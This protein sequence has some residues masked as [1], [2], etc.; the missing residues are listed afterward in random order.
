MGESHNPLAL[1]EDHTKRL[2]FQHRKEL[3]RDE[4]KQQQ[5]YTGL[6]GAR[7][8]NGV[9]RIAMGLHLSTLQDTG[10]WMGRSGAK[11]FRRFLL[12]EGIQPSAAYQYMTVAKTFLLEH[13]VV[14]ER[15][16]MVSMRLLVAASRYLRLEDPEAGTEANTD[17]IVSIVTSMPVAEALQLLR[18]WYEPLAVEA[19]MPAPG[20]VSRPVAGILNTVETLTHE[21]RAEL[22]RALRFKPEAVPTPRTEKPSIQVVPKGSVTPA[23]NPVPSL[24]SGIHESGTNELKSPFANTKSSSARQF[25][26]PAFIAVT[27]IK[28]LKT[29]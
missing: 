10:G 18:E 15:I 14:P 16:A 27:A 12:E 22:Y 6:K 25:L 17:D 21:G 3:A 29:A 7:L 20:G 19:E 24:E 9:A 13:A 5:A 11:S 4:M 8:A 26:R 28:A 1:D 23:P 2:S